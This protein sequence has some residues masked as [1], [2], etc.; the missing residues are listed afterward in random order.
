MIAEI[1]ATAGSHC[2]WTKL[3]ASVLKSFGQLLEIEGEV[4]VIVRHQAP[5]KYCSDT[6]SG[7]I[8]SASI[9]IVSELVV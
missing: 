3:P 6:L 9:L 4:V 8:Q 1:A 2:L 5:H 7:W